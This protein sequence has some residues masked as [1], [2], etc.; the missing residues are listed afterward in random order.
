MSPSP[1]RPPDRPT[2]SPLHSPTHSPTHSRP[3][4]VRAERPPLSDR[5]WLQR[6][7]ASMALLVSGLL[8]WGYSI[9]QGWPL[10]WSV[11]GFLALGNGAIFTPL[12]LLSWRDD[13]RRRRRERRH[14]QG[15]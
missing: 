1:I 6:T 8:F 9:A 10:W 7:F 11:I 14:E 12:A 5:A 15:G 13:H 3:P 2:R 4:A